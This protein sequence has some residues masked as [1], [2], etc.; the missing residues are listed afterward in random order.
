MFCSADGSK[1][2]TL[3]DSVMSSG[4]VATMATG[5]KVPCWKKGCAGAMNTDDKYDGVAMTIFM[6]TN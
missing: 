2:L 4:C 5:N 1:L 6:P 3:G